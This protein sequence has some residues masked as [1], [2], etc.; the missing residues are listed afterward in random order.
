MNVLNLSPIREA[1]QV[2][3]GTM[4]GNGNLDP[5]YTEKARVRVCHS[6]IQF[7]YMFW[8]LQ[9]LY[10]LVGSFH[11][12]KRSN[13][14]YS[15]TPVYMSHSRVDRYLWHIYKDMYVHKG[16][17]MRLNVLRRMT[18]LALAVWYQ[19]VGTLVKDYEYRPYVNLATHR[20]SLEENEIACRYFKEQWGLDFHVLQQEGK[21]TMQYF[22]RS[23]KDS[24]AKFIALVKPYI[25]EAMR[26]MI[27]SSFQRTEHPYVGDDVLRSLQQCK[28]LI[29]NI[30]TL[31]G[32]V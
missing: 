12:Y 30:S 19:D 32:K 1:K 27:D 25:H 28:E 20:Y 26:Y 4:F 7:P 16:R 6:S 18:P 24:A 23:S 31:Q 22:I 10:P 29:R 11:F 21:S 14:G 8:K 5:V 15:D 13:N 2:L 9:M 3:L 17:T